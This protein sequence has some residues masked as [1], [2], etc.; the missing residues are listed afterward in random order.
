MCLIERE[1]D[2]DKK[3]PYVHT[4]T[5]ELLYKLIINYCIKKNI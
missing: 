5:H 3:K 1:R 4:H 2:R